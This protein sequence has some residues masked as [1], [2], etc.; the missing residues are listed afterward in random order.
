MNSPEYRDMPISKYI[1]DEH[2]YYNHIFA[3]YSAKS[4]EEEEL[5]LNGQVIYQF[6]Q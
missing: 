4:K 5:G 6:V 1:R 2:E 3:K